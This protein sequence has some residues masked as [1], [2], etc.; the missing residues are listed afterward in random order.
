M[1]GLRRGWSIARQI[2][3][4][5][6]VA[7][8]LLT[9]ANFLVTFA[10]PPPRPAPVQIADLVP[11]LQGAAPDARRHSR[12]IVE[13]NAAFAARDGEERRSD[14]EDRVVTLLKVA[15]AR[16]QVASTQGLLGGPS[17]NSL[18]GAFSV[19]L[20]T[21]SGLWRVVRSVPQPLLTQWHRTTIAITIGL[22]LLLGLIAA[23][24]TKGIVRPIQ[25]LAREADQAYLDGRRGEITVDGPPEIAHL[26]GT[27][28][29]MRDRFAV[30]VENRTM[31][32]A[33]ISHDMATPLARL[34]FH[35]AKLPVNA[36]AQAEADMAELS[37]LIASILSYA[38]G[39]QQLE[40]KP[41]A[42]TELVCDLV[43]RR[44]R[45]DAPITLERAPQEAWVAG[46]R[47]ALQRLLGNLISNAQRYAGGGRIEI[48]MAERRVMLSLIDAGPG[49][50]PELAE[51]VFEPF[52]RIEGS[53]NRETAGAGLGLATARAIAEAHGGTITA[54]SVPGEGARFVL[55]L[56][57]LERVI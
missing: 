15:P 39:Q 3:L 8:L 54:S 36:R 52:F 1:T 35:V 26:A 27:I 33:A 16:V 57:V 40:S 5:I 56:P 25:R 30:M 13:S 41:V 23:R 20:R 49:F 55:T 51:Q 38:R 53:R 18:V 4:L 47:L 37:A 10:G 43:E 21:E 34:E 31:M 24:I 29:A 6:F 2:G 48:D 45:S 44:S 11:I 19:G 42:L 14:A 28:A 50:D 7:L 32:L 17:E 22:T 12:L 9:A 46:D